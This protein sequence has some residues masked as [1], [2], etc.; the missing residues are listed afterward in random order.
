MKEIDV[1]ERLE[2]VKQLKNVD[3]REIKMLRVK[4][5]AEE[6]GL[7]LNDFIKFLGLQWVVMSKIWYNNGV[8]LNKG[9]L[10]QIA[11]FLGV[12]I[13]ELFEDGDINDL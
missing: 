12:E 9:T 7:K 8:N 11:A 6:Q 4:E 13:K 3:I 10:M 5:L 2:R 1:V